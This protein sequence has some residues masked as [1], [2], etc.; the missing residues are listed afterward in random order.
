M[1]R[2]KWF[3]LLVPLASVSSFASQSK[4]PTPPQSEF[5]ASHSYFI[6]LLELVLE[7]TAIDYGPA[8]V[9]FS[10]QMEQGRAFL[11]LERN[12]ALDVYWAGTS[13]SREQRLKAIRIPLVK[14]MLG[15][16]QFVIHRDRRQDFAQIKNLSDLQKMVACQGAHW[17]DSDVLEGAGLKVMR[18]PIYENMFKQVAAGRCDYFPRG[19]HE[20]KAEVA[21]RAQAYPSLIWYQD[22]TLY[23]PFPMYFFVS[24][25]NPILQQRITLG[26]EA[27]VADGS[28]E[29]YMQQDST[30]A[31]LFP[32]QKWLKIKT[33]VIKN[34]QL[35]ADTPIRD[36]RYW[37]QPPR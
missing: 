13:I 6:G 14:G 28:F 22:L 21:A 17:P 29:R 4:K 12:A 16:R 34:Q 1:Q 15:F 8:E 37:V 24:A 10:M 5:D 33:I 9:V 23:Y 35:S 26:L 36:L 2:L 19:V 11:E 30:T 7:K 27:A 32:L 25:S 18:N 31:H 3:L 20:G